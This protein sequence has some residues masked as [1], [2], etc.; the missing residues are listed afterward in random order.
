ME[1]KMKKFLITSVIIVIAAALILFLP[2]PLP[3][4]KDG[5]TKVYV[6]LTYKIVSWN[7]YLESSPDGNNKGDLHIY[8][9]VSIYWFSDKYKSIDELWEIEMSKYK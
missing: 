5:G 9:K 4:V 7:R 8:R 3:T 1:V 6:S 2:I